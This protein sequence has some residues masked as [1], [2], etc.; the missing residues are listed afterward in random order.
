MPTPCLLVPLFACLVPAAPLAEAGLLYRT[1]FET[2]TAGDDLWVGADDGSGTAPW[3]GIDTGLGVHGIDQDVIPGG[4]LG[5]TAFIGFRQPASTLV[6]VAKPIL[7]TPGPADLPRVRV[8]T[9]IGIQDSSPN[10]PRDS[11]FVSVY[12]SAGDFLAGIRFDN[13]QATYGIWRADGLNPDHDTG[14]IFYRGELH[15]LAFTVDL[16]NNKWSADLDGVPLFDDAPFTATARPVGF[17]H[18]AYEWQLNATSAE[19]FGNNWM[20]IADTVVRSV[21]AGIEPFRLSGITRTSGATTLSWPGEN[22]F[23]Y[24]VEYSDALGTWHADLPGSSFP[25]ISADQPLTFQ[26]PGAAGARRFYRVVR[27]ETP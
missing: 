9:L 20:L 21:P 10:A 14:V 6:F 1:D 17:G 25:G 3:L 24:Q 19:G 7:Y 22:G 26:D 11:F 2:F 23:D 4:G 13:R 8:E 12:N 16:P 18:L 15:V 27:Q 5:K